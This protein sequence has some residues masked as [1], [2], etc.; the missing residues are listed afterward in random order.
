MPDTLNTVIDT[1]TPAPVP[2]S[3]P[4][5][6]PQPQAV[7][8]V[9]PTADTEAQPPAP[10]APWEM[11]RAEQAPMTAAESALYTTARVSY[12]QGIEPTPR[13]QTIATDSGVLLLLTATLL[14]VA[15]N[16]KHCYRLF[17]VLGQELVSV[18][19]RNN[20]FDDTTTNETR[21]LIVLLFELWVCEGLIGYTWLTQQGFLRGGTQFLPVAAMVAVAMIF[22]LFQLV[23]YRVVGYVFTDHI[24]ALQWVKGYNA[25]QA[26]LGITLLV[27]ALITL[28]YPMWLTPVLWVAFGLYLL[29]RIV[30]IIKGFRIFYENFGSLLYFILYLCALEI[31]PVV[32]CVLGS[33]ELSRHFH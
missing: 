19:R 18:R 24:G 20:V 26:F 30:F 22:F 28:F 31:I 10:T 5:S 15:F 17:K 12:T 11:L 6:A 8:V 1:L 33:I 13:T 7:A 23:S 29:A 3:V 25:S 16:F 27:P 2:E 21:V 9:A 4:E 32:V 14:L